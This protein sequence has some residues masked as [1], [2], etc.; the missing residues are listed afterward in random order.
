MKK[1]EKWLESNG[2]DNVG[3][4]HDKLYVIYEKTGIFSR[5][6][7]HVGLFKMDVFYNQMESYVESEVGGLMFIGPVCKNVDES[8]QKAIE[9]IMEMTKSVDQ[10]LEG[11]I[12][13]K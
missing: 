2:F 4:S 3:P 5:G 13:D 1:N 9:G 6:F 10:L 8:I 12:V 7:G 11:I